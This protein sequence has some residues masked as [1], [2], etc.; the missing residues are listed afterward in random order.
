V[1]N[2]TK[3]KKN[4]STCSAITMHR[5]NQLLYGRSISINVAQTCFSPAWLYGYALLL[6]LINW[7][8]D[9]IQLHS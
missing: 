8:K 2:Q 5:R 3:Q 1:H 9:R 7:V 6:Q 4:M